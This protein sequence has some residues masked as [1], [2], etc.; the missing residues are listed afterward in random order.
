[1]PEKK[2]VIN[3]CFV[4][5]FSALASII[6][7]GMLS[8]QEDFMEIKKILFADDDESLQLLVKISLKKIK[9][10]SLVFAST[11]KEAVEQAHAEKP[12]LILMDVMMPVMSGVEAIRIIKNDPEI[13]HIPIIIMS[14]VS[15]QQKVKEFKEL[16]V[17][18]IISKPYSPKQ[19]MKKIRGLMS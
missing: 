17:F 11:G 16:G 7:M 1:M 10:V 13:K 12:D 19:L 5:A 4:F 9:S 14:A 15:N 3:L 6:F 2:E 18:G 8:L